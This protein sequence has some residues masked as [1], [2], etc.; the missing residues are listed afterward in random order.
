MHFYISTSMLVLAVVLFMMRYSFVSD[1]WQYFGSM[2]IIALAASLMTRALDGAGRWQR[3]LRLGLGVALILGLGALTWAQCG[4]YSDAE[5]LWTAAIA[6][7]PDC[8]MARNNLGLIS[9]RQGRADE[10]IAQFREALRIDPEIAEI[11]ASLGTALFQRGQRE[12]GLVEL[13]DAVRINPD[14]AVARV[15]VGNALLEEGLVDA[16]VAQYREAVRISPGYAEANNNLGLALFH[17]G[18]TGEAIAQYR[19]AVRINPAYAEAHYNLGNALIQQGEAGDAIEHTEE[20]LKLQPDNPAIQNNLAWMLAAAPQTS[21]R[22]GA[23][24]VQLAREA[25]QSG[26]GGNPTILHTLAAAYAEAGDFPDAVQT[27][28]KALQLAEVQSNTSLPAALRREIK[29]YEA[30]HAYEAPRQ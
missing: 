11:H 15:N 14:Y 3:P 28:R 20:A 4:M 13:R 26:G 10:A 19:E 18:R 30:G 25:S 2:G 29:L 12:E 23:R 7:N 8:W 17:L 1:H 16:A 21:L 27:A 24:A 5:T 22:N 6:R 9:L